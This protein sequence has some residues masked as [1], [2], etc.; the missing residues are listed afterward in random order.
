MPT[1]PK[2]TT[3]V[4]KCAS[5]TERI[6][7]QLEAGVAP[8]VRP[9]TTTGASDLP[10]NVSSNQPYR[11]ANVVQ[12]WMAQT[13]FGYPTAEWV[14][15]KQAISLGGSVRKG[16][17]G[18]PVFYVSAFESKTETDRNG[19]PRR[20]P[21]L[22]A[23]TV[24]NV[25]Q[26]D[27]L[28]ARVAPALRTENER[29]AD[30]EAYVSAI[31]ADIREGGDRAFYSPSLDFIGMPALAQFSDAAA[32]YGTK[33]HEL[34]HWT[35]AEKRL[36]RTFGKRFGDN[37]YAF[38]ELVAELTAAFL[39]AELGIAGR[40]QHPEYIAHWLGILKGDAKA[41]W[42]AGARAADAVRYLHEAAGRVAGDDELATAA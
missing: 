25:A 13:A 30:V 6:I 2:T 8:W 29:L 20:I 3:N 18:T 32:Y 19:D 33:L 5:V 16:E 23:Y 36:A 14:T 27:G 11:G 38:E 17:H 39:C 1:Q 24:F 10:V 35:G 4:D 26:C 22:K 9:W 31:G 21:F 15:F 41:I 34:G 42:T 40:L 37:A 12:L 7:E 28:P